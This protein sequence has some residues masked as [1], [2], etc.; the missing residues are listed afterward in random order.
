M[1]IMFDIETLDT[2]DTAVVLSIGAVLFDK[3]KVPGEEI[4]DRFYRVLD[5]QSQID[6]GRTISQST[7]LWWL[8]DHDAAKVNARAEA[9]NPVRQPVVESLGAF[10]GWAT[11]T[12]VVSVNRYWCVGP[13]FDGAIMNNLALDFNCEVPWRYNQLRDVRTVVDEASYS[14][15]DHDPGYYIA[16]VAHAPVYDCEW[17]VSLLSAARHKVGR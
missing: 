3:T 15:D 5:I 8:S 13:H 1:E 6:A 2:A 4:V 11:Q 7:L 16:G 12:P 10:Y 17:Q 14:V 9:F